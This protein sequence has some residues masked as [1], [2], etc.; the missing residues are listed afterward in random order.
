[1]KLIAVIRNFQRW[2]YPVDKI[3]REILEV[4]KVINALSPDRGVDIE[5]KVYKYFPSKKDAIDFAKRWTK[6][7]EDSFS[8]KHIDVDKLNIKFYSQSRNISVIRKYEPNDE[9]KDK[10]GILYQNPALFFGMKT[11][12][13]ERGEEHYDLW[14]YE[15]CKLKLAW[16]KE[17]RDYLIKK[18][19]FMGKNTKG[20]G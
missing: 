4:S 7:S 12:T 20:N 2:W 10:G 17:Y 8:V 11:A 5:G 9:S 15:F 1:M 13:N 14:F 18:N 3:E 6:G 19:K 16:L